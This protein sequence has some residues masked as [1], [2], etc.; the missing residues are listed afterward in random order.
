M[1][2]ISRC[3]AVAGSASSQINGHP[4]VQVKVL[5]SELRAASAD[6]LDWRTIY[7]SLYDGMASSSTALPRCRD[8][9]QRNRAIDLILEGA[10]HSRSTLLGADKFHNDRAVRFN[11]LTVGSGQFH[12]IGIVA[13]RLPIQLQRS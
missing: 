9:G 12:F 6:G 13:L 2:W 10:L 8:D 7:Q 3:E 11:G 5:A 1:K 4:E